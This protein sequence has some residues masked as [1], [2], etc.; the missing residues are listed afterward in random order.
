[1]NGPGNCCSQCPTEYAIEGSIMDLPLEQAD[2]INGD[3]VAGD[4]GC[5]DV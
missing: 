1:M 4:E 5:D 3:H 2:K